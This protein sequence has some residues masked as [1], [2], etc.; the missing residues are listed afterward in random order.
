MT[1]MPLLINM[2]IALF[3]NLPNVG[4]LPPAGARIPGLIKII[5][6]ITMRTMMILIKTGFLEVF[7]SETVS[8]SIRQ[9]RLISSHQSSPPSRS[10]FEGDVI[11]GGLF[12]VH[13]KSETETEV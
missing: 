4:G 9:L 10:Y 7:I 12:P 8:D 11:L 1:Q 6:I 13:E 2:G 3:L 5:T